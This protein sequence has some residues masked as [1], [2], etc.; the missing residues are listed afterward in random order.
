MR[1][2][3]DY[4]PTEKQRAFHNAPDDEVLYGGAAGGGKSCA[5]VADAFLRCA[6]HP[7]SRAYLF[8]RTYPE[9]RDTLIK[10]ALSRYPQGY[11]RYAATVHDWVFPNGSVICFR[12]C[13]GP[14]DKYKY[15]G[16]EIDFLYI[17]ELT[18]FEKDVVDYLKTRVRSTKRKNIKPVVRYASNPGNIGHAWVKEKF[19]DPGHFG[20]SIV[21][22][23]YSDVLKRNRRY[24]QKYIPALLT[25]NPHLQDDYV[26]ELERKPAAL[27]DALLHGNWD[28]FEGQVF[29]EW[30]NDPNGY[31]S[32][33]GTHVIEPFE[34]P[35][36]WNRYM[37]F[38]HGFSKPFS[39]G[40]W[41]MDYEGR[42][43]RYREWY[44]NNGEPNVGMQITPMEIVDGIL[45]RETEERRN[46]IYINRVAD[47][48]IFNRSSGK[49]VA[50]QM[51]GN[52]L[53]P[54]ISF[55]D[56]DNN[57]LAGK[58]EFHERLRFDEQGKPMMYV[59]NTCRDFIRTIPTLPYSIKVFEDVDSEAE[60]HIYDETRYFLMM[61]PLKSE[62]KMPV[63]V[64]IPGPLDD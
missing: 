42:A 47:P 28:A 39:V 59:F 4:E 51:Q 41:A 29:T 53:R 49:S 63:R 19:I 1:F 57:R 5:I 48:A 13:N 50:E 55:I 15:Q 37:S 52:E 16:A 45:S 54:G 32:R 36:N 25:D 64:R 14:N 7:G 60:D 3:F 2:V 34:I 30:K 21:K 38:D 18:T 20:E 12:H 46:N 58:M 22:T 23:E 17:D 56:G 43:Y 10:E 27:R 11:G 6:Y 31:L 62:R 40:W 35:L 8:R 33:I 61:N 9:L 26:F 44:G 24:T